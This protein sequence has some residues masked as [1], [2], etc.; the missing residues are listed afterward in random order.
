[1]STT[2]RRTWPGCGVGATDGNSV[3]YVRLRRKHGWKVQLRAG[4]LGRS[5]EEEEESKGGDPWKRK[6]LDDRQN[7]VWQ[8]ICA[9]RGSSQLNDKQHTVV[10]DG[11]EGTGCRVLA[12]KPTHGRLSSSIHL[13]GERTRLQPET[14]GLHNNQ[15]LWSSAATLP[16]W[17]FYF[18]LATIKP[19]QKFAKLLKLHLEYFLL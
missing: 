3:A 19:T 6:Q 1:M 8:K 15:S 16:E 5:V 12:Q 13:S 14:T 4:S 2:V 7:V 18:A 9:R 10:T 17:V 11:A